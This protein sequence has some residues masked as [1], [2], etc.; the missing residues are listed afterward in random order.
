[1]FLFEIIL[2][3]IIY[4]YMHR[5]PDIR[6]RVTS[7]MRYFGYYYIIIHFGTR[8]VKRNKLNCFTGFRT[9]TIIIK[10]KFHIRLD[11]IKIQK[12]KSIQTILFN[13]RC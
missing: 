8:Y 12:V 5:T 7:A 9:F 11:F 4:K 2:V 10:F 13:S 6:P 1:M 3:Y